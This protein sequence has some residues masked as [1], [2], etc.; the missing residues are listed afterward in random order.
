MASAVS[1]SFLQIGVPL[2]FMSDS[3]RNFAHQPKET[4]FLSHPKQK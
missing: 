1:A 2:H 4:P 3:A